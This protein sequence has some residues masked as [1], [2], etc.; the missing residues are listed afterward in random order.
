MFGTYYDVTLAI[1][2]D[3]CA[4]KNLSYVEEAVQCAATIAE[5]EGVSKIEAT[6]LERIF[7]NYS[8]TFEV[9]FYHKIDIN[10]SCG[11]KMKPAVS[12]MRIYHFRFI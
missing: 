3:R 7:H 2:Q 4:D 9:K 6:P 8:W 5:V 12:Y 10:F 1:M 11:A